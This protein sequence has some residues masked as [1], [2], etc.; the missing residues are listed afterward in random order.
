MID[1]EKP[2]EVV[3]TEITGTSQENMNRYHALEL[4]TRVNNFETSTEMILNRAKDFLG[5]LEGENEDSTGK[6]EPEE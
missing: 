2:V 5:F 3:L 6:S 1:E 4:A